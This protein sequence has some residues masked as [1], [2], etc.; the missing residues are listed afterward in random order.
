MTGCMAYLQFL[1][2]KH[3]R[4]SVLE[5]AFGIG[6]LRARNTVGLTYSRGALQQR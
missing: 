5:K 4:M 1:A 3:K 2:L 6:R